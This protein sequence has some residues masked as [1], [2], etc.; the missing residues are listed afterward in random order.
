M[1]D[2]DI[3]F[4]LTVAHEGYYV[5]QDY[6]RAR[7]DNKSGETYMGI[8]R[9]ANPG[10]AGWPIIDAYKASH[11]AIA[12][13]TRL[14]QSLGLEPL[15]EATAKANY[16]DHIHGDEIKDQDM[17]NLIFESYWGS[18]SFGITQVQQSINKISDQPVNLDGVFGVDTLNAV[19]NAPQAPLYSQIY[20]DRKDWYV[21]KLNQGNP[22]ASGWLTRLGSFPS[23]ISEA[24]QDISIAADATVQAVAANPI[25]TV[26]AILFLISGCALAYYQFFY[27][28]NTTQLLSNGNQ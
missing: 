16:W 6:W 27:V 23:S 5:S 17:A 8:D 18:G 2:F 26:V 11:G 22:N 9:I 1:A 10:W 19:N 28:K 21:S 20:N 12:Y 24:Q 25:I 3:A 15:V 14:P 7:G 4:P 13:N